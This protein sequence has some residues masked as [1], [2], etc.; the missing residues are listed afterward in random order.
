M[1]TD[2]VID[3]IGAV[4]FDSLP[5]SDQRLRAQQYV[6]GLLTAD[7]RK[8]LRNIAEQIGGTT[9]RQSVHHFISD[10]SWDWRPVRQS[11]A[12]HVEALLQP[13]AWVVR[14]TVIPKAGVHSV[15]VEP[16][17]VPA[18]GQT[19]NSQQAYGA[20]LV[21]SHAVPT[22]WRLQLTES[23]LADAGR[24][25][26]A[27]I[28]ESVNTAT[29]EACVRQL[30]PASGAGPQRL[31]VVVSVPGLDV[32]ECARHLEGVAGPLL[33]RLDPGTRLRPDGAVLQ[34]YSDRTTTAGQLAEAAGRLRR[35]AEWTRTRDERGETLATTLPVHL[36]APAREP[37][38][39]R[40]DS[41]ARRP[42]RLVAEWSGDDR[43]RPRL[44]LTDSA[45]LPLGT[46]LRLTR[47]TDT[48][49]RDAARI[50]DAVGMRD[51]VGRS[52]QGWHRHVTLASVAHL[53][54]VLA[55]TAAFP[56][57]RPQQEAGPAGPAG[58]VA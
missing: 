17:F 56:A 22:D 35:P 2:Q 32:T 50:A 34:P 6:R 36:P 4:L 21:G 47:L 30:M 1:T 29:A 52:Y 45:D 13:R 43:R 42:L 41:A 12:A 33:F 15:G 44:W 38:A 48:A 14:P 8:T 58:H 24:R 19:V 40:F 10:S 23:W 51:F 16:R 39:G 55:G 25:Q 57:T 7:G 54:V 26:R 27:N 11:L 9:A 3:D 18:T 20:W 37:A 28:P 53:A 31:P 5:R 49:D 46:L